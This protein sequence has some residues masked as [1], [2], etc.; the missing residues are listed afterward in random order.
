MRARA[1]ILF[2]VSCTACGTTS[3]AADTSFAAIQQRGRDVMGVDQYGSKHVFEDQRDGGRIILERMDSTDRMAIRTIRAHMRDIADA[4]SRG[5]FQAPGLVHARAV[6]GTDAMTQRR[7]W[8][9]YQVTDLPRGAEV[10][11]TTTDSSAVVAIHQ[12]L[13]FQRTD[14]RAAGHHMN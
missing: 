8:I 13:A 5:D 7:D 14:H 4:F 1:V 6:P 9:T 2:V 3:R 10:R 12:F 11:I